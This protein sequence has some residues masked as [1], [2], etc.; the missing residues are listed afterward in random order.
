MKNDADK[1]ELGLIIGCGAALAV[2]AL[3]WIAVEVLL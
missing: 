2:I 3:V 1:F